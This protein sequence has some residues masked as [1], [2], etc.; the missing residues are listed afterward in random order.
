[1]LKTISGD[2]I[3]MAK[4][5][6]FDVIIHGCNCFNTMGAGIAKQI[7]ATWPGAYYVDCKTPNGDIAK[8][9][10]CSQYVARVLNNKPLLIINA[11]TQFRYYGEENERLVNY[12]AIRSVFHNLGKLT[13]VLGI[14]A[15]IGIPRIGAGLAGGDWNVIRQIIEEETNDLDITLVEYTK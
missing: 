12:D 14:K 6:M 1:M 4:A 11:Y 2:L 9:G 13:S 15:R 5:G 3:E 8:L 7:R 10:T